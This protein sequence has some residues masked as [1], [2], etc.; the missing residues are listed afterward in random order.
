MNVISVDLNARLF[1]PGNTEQAVGFYQQVFGGQVT[2][3]RHGD[4]DLLA[5]CER[6]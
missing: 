3:T 1:F 2:I 5:A 4:V 6:S